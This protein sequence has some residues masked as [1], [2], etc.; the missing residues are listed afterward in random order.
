MMFKIDTTAVGHYQ[1]LLQA[2]TP[3]VRSEKVG[4]T[5][6]VCREGSMSAS[7]EV[8][9]RV[10]ERYS[11]NV[12]NEA[13]SLPNVHRIDFFSWRDLFKNACSACRPAFEI[14]NADK[15]KAAAPIWLDANNNILI[16]T[17]EGLRFHGFVKVYFPGTQCQRISEPV[18]IP[19]KF[20]IC[21][22]ERVGVVD[23]AS[24]LTQ[25]FVMGIDP[26]VEL[27]FDELRKQFKTDSEVC[28]VKS[29]QVVSEY[30]GVYYDLSPNLASRFSYSST[31][32][33]LINYL[34]AEQ[35]L[36][37]YIR[38]ISSGKQFAHK[39][40]K[41]SYVSNQAPTIG[42]DL[43]NVIEVREDDDNAGQTQ[44]F[45]LYFKDREGDRVVKYDLSPSLDNVAWVKYQIIGQSDN[46][47][48]L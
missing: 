15:V 25:K 33:K 11:T 18:Y 8:I 43:A 40:L 44:D 34:G 42:G 30:A 37:V 27:L 23:T 36:T 46:I 31:G 19:L 4:V 17:T 14:V 41:I 5:A 48:G 28:T 26:D 16:K 13:E 47:Q 12:F 3:A 32:I 22:Q 38:A 35:D 2:S 39:P 1:F 21:G 10:I 20:E 24:T 45:N 6:A 29:F 7:T 9:S